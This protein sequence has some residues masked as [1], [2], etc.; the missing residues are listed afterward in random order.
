M[1]TSLSC[2]TKG[3]VSFPLH[4]GSQEFSRRCFL[5]GGNALTYKSERAYGD[6]KHSFSHLIYLLLKMSSL[7]NPKKATSAGWYM[8]TVHIKAHKEGCS[9]QLL[10]KYI[11][12]RGLSIFGGLFAAVFCMAL[13]QHVPGASVCMS[14]KLILEIRSLTGSVHICWTQFVKT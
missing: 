8:R 2:S 10:H 1:A 9:L 6:T 13:F 7:N 11:Q 14:H 12:G 4:R 5:E 3:N